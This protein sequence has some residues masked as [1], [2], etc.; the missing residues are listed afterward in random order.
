[1][2]VTTTA[3]REQITQFLD[4]YI[5]SWPRDPGPWYSYSR[6]EQPVATQVTSAQ[7]AENLVRSAEFRALQLGTWLN[8]PDGE[9]ITAAVEAITPPPYRQDIELITDA[10]KLAAQQ[11]RGEGIGRAILNSGMAA[12][13]FTFLIAASKT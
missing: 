5:A 2:P 9:L 6:W 13:G 8:K 7:L 1:M 3:T 4:R 10:L 12:L 11:Q